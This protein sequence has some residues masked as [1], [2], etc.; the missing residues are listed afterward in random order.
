MT[1]YSRNTKRDGEASDADFGLTGYR[2]PPRY[3]GSRFRRYP[4]VS[5]PAAER[6]RERPPE[7][8]PEKPPEKRPE[9]AP[10]P[11]KDGA[12]RLIRG[13]FGDR[14]GQEELMI[15]TL[16]LILSAAGGDGCDSP[17]ETVLLLALLLLSSS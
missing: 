17:G 3:D 5:P 10:R 1:V 2:L 15:L 6:P 8:P 4:P 11:G 12:L 14:L 13:L 16:I 9:P 7:R